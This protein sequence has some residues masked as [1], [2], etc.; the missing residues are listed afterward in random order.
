MQD[1]D[2]YATVPFKTTIVYQ[3]ISTRVAPGPQLQDISRDQETSAVRT[4]SGSEMCGLFSAADGP[5]FFT[6]SFSW[7]D[8]FSLLIAQMVVAEIGIAEV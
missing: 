3:A 4:P 5:L 7:L 1:A 2:D 6:L 8:F